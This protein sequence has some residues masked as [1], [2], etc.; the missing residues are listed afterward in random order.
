MVEIRTLELALDYS[1]DMT[2]YQLCSP[3][4]R[5]VRQEERTSLVGGLLQQWVDLLK[6]SKMAQMQKEDLSA[7]PP[8][9]YV[10]W[11]VDRLEEMPVVVWL[12]RQY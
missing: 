12:R 2:R 9:S 11:R 8:P 1:R 6:A 10:P 7:W 5:T 4:I 3:Q